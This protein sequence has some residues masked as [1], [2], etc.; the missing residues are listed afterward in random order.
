MKV[1][2]KGSSEPVRLLAQLGRILGLQVTTE[3]QGDRIDL[4][5]PAYQLSFRKTRNGM[6]SR[7]KIV[8]RNMLWYLVR[9]KRDATLRELCLTS[10][11]RFLLVR[12]CGKGVL[13]HV[14]ETLQSHGLRLGMSEEELN[15]Y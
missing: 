4:N 2:I 12:N 6:H 3:V 5:M 11:A 10:E 9:E 14:N 1:T 13:K 7:A 15:N 8:I